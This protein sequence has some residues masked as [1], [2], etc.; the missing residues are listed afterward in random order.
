VSGR[1]VQGRSPVPAIAGSLAAGAALAVV[2]LLGP[3]TNGGEPVITGAALLAFGIGWGLMAPLTGRFS[4]Q[5][6]DWTRVPGVI[7]AAFGLALLAFQPGPAVMDVLGWLWP[8]AIAAL[9][10][11]MLAQV[12]RQLHGRGS[13]LVTPV[14]GGLFALALG[15]GL[16][17][18]SGAVSASDPAAPG[19]LIDV[20]GHRLYLECE[21]RGAPVVVLQSGL[22][23][24]SAYWERIA[25][26]VASATTVCRYDRAGHGHS[27][28]VTTPQDGVAVAADLHTLLERAGL[29]GPYVLVG[30][31]SGG[32]YVR[33]FAAR[34]PDDVAGMVLLDAQP[35]DAFEALPDYPAFYRGYRA[36]ATLSP[37]LA[38]VGLLGLVLGLPADQSTVA[39]ARGTRDEVLELPEALRQA[40]AL[41]SLGSRPLVV[42]S[43]GSRQQ[44]GWLEAQSRLVQLSSNSA[45]RVLSS[46]THT[47]VISGDDAPA[48]GRAIL[49]VVA[50][51]R[52]GTALR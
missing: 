30:H 34:Y 35:A 6:Q 24:S 45:Q 32:P 20:G 41:T 26:T 47:S 1:V 49:D 21:G 18:V 8:P 25:T 15:G 29:P 36:V 52:G 3:A 33:V 51:V 9:A 5:P 7:L 11:W 12:R 28:E 19:Q 48:S 10:V 50:A 39:A 40:E 46:A 4:G 13:W 43:A 16:T 23:E 31:S 17:T 42:V 38:R 27:D 44:A 14:I 22:G 2:A 37:S